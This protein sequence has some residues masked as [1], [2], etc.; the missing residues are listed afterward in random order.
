MIELF[1][2]EGCAGC[3]RVRQRLSEMMIDFVARQVSPD[4]A[5][6]TRLE[7]ATGQRDVPA[8]LDPDQGMIV[9]EPDDILAY[10]EETYGQR[11]A[12]P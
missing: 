9:T 12:A 8:L 6:R 7:L 3:A 4:P 1:Q 5:H 10:L 2:Y 11:K